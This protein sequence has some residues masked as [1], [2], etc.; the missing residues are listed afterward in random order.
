MYDRAKVVE[1]SNEAQRRIDVLKTLLERKKF[2]EA[3]KI[4]LVG[5]NIEDPVRYISIS[6]VLDVEFLPLLYNILKGSL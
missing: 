2:V 3:A 4:N 6:G 1:A 5:G